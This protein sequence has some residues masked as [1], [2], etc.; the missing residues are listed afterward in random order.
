MKEA[1]NKFRQFSR[2]EWIDRV[3]QSLKSEDPSAFRWEPR[4]GITGLPFA[5]QDDLIK[6]ELPPITDSGSG[7]SWLVGGY[8]MGELSATER[9][10]YQVLTI[11]DINQLIGLAGDAGLIE[12]SLQEIRMG[13]ELF[14]AWKRWNET[15]DPVLHK[16]F[17]KIRWVLIVDAALEIDPGLIRELQNFTDQRPILALQMPEP[18]DKVPFISTLADYFNAW[19][20]WFTGVMAASG[21]NR[22][23][24]SPRIAY[25]IT[26]ADF[27]FETA[28]IRALKLLAYNVQASIGLDVQDVAIDGF[29]DTQKLST[30]PN[31]RLI[32][33]TTAAVSAVMAGVHSLFIG[34]KEQA[35]KDDESLRLYRNIQLILREESGMADVVDPLA[36]SYAIE[37]LTRVLSEAVWSELS[38]QK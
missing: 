16:L 21:G 5:H 11:T 31:H 10:G 12:G 19:K 7:N 8:A 28:V 14:S 30:D 35:A 22:E 18:G 6:G 29:I 20:V 13:A 36:G 15:A 24:A 33:G 37:H 3:T 32:L 4:E 34:S 25:R 9:L 26:T 38:G 2:Q 1:K 23:G 27:L 17:S